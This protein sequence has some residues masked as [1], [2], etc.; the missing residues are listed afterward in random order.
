MNTVKLR[1]NAK[2]NLSLYISGKRSDGYHEIDTVMQSISLFDR[3]TVK[4]ADS[5]TL[6]CSKKHLSGED[7]LGF[8]AAQLFFKETDIKSGAYIYIKK[9]IPEAGGLGG[10][11]ADAGAVLVALDRLYSTDLPHQVLEKMAAS[12][13]ADVPFFIKGGTQRCTGIGEILTPLSPFT[14]GFFVIA[15]GGNKP[16]TGEMYRRLDVAPQREIDI[17]SS[18]KYAQSNDLKRLCKYLHNSFNEVWEDKSFE[19]HLKE[20]NPLGVGLSGS[21][22]TYF[23][24]FSSYLKAKKCEKA[25]K[26]QGVTAFC[27]KPKKNSVIFE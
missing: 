15:K 12:L 16:S 20:F 18:V 24:V 14:K 23:A 2:I 1:V 8:K 7:N 21:G 26:K 22:P 19:N 5:I 4:K 11:S 17:D 3:I 6:E 10:G 9:N 13:G 27:V 25:L